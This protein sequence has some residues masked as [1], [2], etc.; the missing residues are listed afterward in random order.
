MK[1][2]DLKEARPGEP[3]FFGHPSRD[4]SYEKLQ[5]LE[6]T[7]W[8][9]DE[10]YPG[11]VNGDVRVDHNNLVD[12]K[13]SPRLV[14][15]KFW[16]NNNSLRNLDGGPRRVREA[17][18]AYEN[19]LTSVKGA[20][21]ECGSLHLD[22]NKL[23][24]I[25]GPLGNVIGDI[26]LN[27]NQL[28]H[29]KNIHKLIEH[30]GGELKIAGNKIKS[31]ILGILLIPGLKSVNM[32]DANLE[33]ELNR[34]LPNERGMDAVLELQADLIQNYNGRYDEHAKL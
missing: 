5:T 17:Y 12:L 34:L 31:H 27:D 4:H 29:L 7:E 6:G 11:M 15:G 26:D 32:D 9:Y 20:P 14:H 3:Q 19:Q 30:C 8:P 33:T 23:T 13:G 22:S 1:L 10:K 24:E 18:H 21:T 25:D 16:C 2:T 28:T